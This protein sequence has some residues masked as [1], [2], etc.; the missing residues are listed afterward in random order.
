MSRRKQ[1]SQEKT[2]LKEISVVLKETE[3][4][5]PNTLILQL[6]FKNDFAIIVQMS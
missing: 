1:F 2:Q 6:K 3:L 5:I 4:P